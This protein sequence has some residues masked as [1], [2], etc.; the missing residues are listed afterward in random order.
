MVEAETF[1]QE[2]R[3]GSSLP[4]LVGG[5][6]G[7]RYVLKLSGGGDGALAHAVGYLASRI[8]QWIEIPVLEPV[9]V[10]VPEGFARTDWD[11]EI[12]ELV[13]KSIGPNLA[14]EYRE[15]ARAYGEE[16]DKQAVTKTVRGFIFLYDLF[17]L[18]VDRGPSNPNMI[19]AEEQL[20]CLDYSSSI[21]MR[22]VLGRE[23]GEKRPFLR[24]LR[25]HPFYSLK[26]DK[27]NFIRLMKAVSDEQLT[28]AV[29][30]LPDEWLAEL[31]PGEGLAEVRGRIVGKLAA[32]RDE[33]NGVVKRLDVLKRLPVETDEER[34]EQVRR[35][36]EAFAQRVGGRT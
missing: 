28:E 23:M 30:E 29:R 34:G 36:K 18:N 15:D 8:A 33:V 10:K 31:F 35:N 21:V 1:L 3:T 26:V 24:Q 2:F 22:G 14:T 11:P 5:S 12:Y 25:G 32:R 13:E 27:Y 4:L 16:G 9:L 6:D 19:L 17:L 7:K 20:F